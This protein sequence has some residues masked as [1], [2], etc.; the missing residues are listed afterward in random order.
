LRRLATTSGVIAVR[1]T[2]QAHAIEGVVSPWPILR[3]HA[4][5]ILVAVLSAFVVLASVDLAIFRSGFFETHAPLSNPDSPAAKRLLLNRLGDVRVL[6]IGDS[7]VLTDIAPGIATEACR[8]GPGFNAAFSAATPWLIAAAAE[9]LIRSTHPNVV[10]LGVSPWAL[11][12]SLGLEDTGRTR[13]VLSPSQLQA[14]GIRVDPRDQIESVVASLWSLY[15]QRALLKDAVS[16][17]LPRQKYDESQRGF[18]V[19][20]GDASAA[21]QLDA[22]IARMKAGISTFPS[23][24]SQGAREL[25][26]LMLE[27]RDAG[28]TVVIVPPPLHPAGQASAPQYLAQADA[29]TRALAQSNQATFLDCRDAVGADDFRDLDHLSVAGATKFSL[30]VGDGLRASP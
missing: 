19:P 8:C 22:G 25:G 28:M 18:F 29:A 26:R 21:A 16:S 1:P 24:A 14:H 13:E 27:L 3:K 7:T 10:V 30:C 6:Y 15:G 11:D 5:S 17:F 12:E 23:L 9:E 2:A 4:H 20:P